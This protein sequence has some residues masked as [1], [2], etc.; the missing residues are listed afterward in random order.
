MSRENETSQEPWEEPG[1]ED[2]YEAD[3]RFRQ[4]PRSS[5]DR[6]ADRPVQPRQRPRQGGNPRETR[7]YPYNRRPKRRPDPSRANDPRQAYDANGRYG[8]GQGTRPPGV[9]NN[10]TTEPPRERPRQTRDFRE[11]VGPHDDVDERYQQRR[12]ISRQPRDE[13]YARQRPRQ[14]IYTRDEAGYDMYA[15]PSP[16]N[17]PLLDPEVE[18]YDRQA[19]RPPHR[20]PPPLSI[21]LITSFS[22]IIPV[23]TSFRTIS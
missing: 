1:E 19:F 4:R 9:S 14:P 22:R 23:L 21:L 16:R 5:R 2:S 20:R 17:R 3:P 18:V 8:K 12:R 13:A 11:Q 7:A 10:K 15:R 6:Y